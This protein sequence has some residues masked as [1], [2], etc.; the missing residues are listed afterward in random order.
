MIDLSG[1][2]EIDQT[3]SPY[4]QAFKRM[5]DNKPPHPTALLGKLGAY[6]DDD[7]HY[8]ARP[9]FRGWFGQIGE[10]FD[11]WNWQSIPNDANLDDIGYVGIWRATIYSESEPI[12]WCVLPSMQCGY[13]APGMNIDFGSERVRI[14][15]K[16]EDLDAMVT[17]GYEIMMRMIAERGEYREKK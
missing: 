6:M 1:V 10:R 13:V 11:V 12:A 4:Y 9:N 2:P 17:Q 16:Q 14:G 8:Q 15:W 7:W 5:E 3:E